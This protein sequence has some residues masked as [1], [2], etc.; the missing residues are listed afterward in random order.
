[1]GPASLWAD[2][3]PPPRWAALDRDER[4]D[5]LV[6]GAGLAGLA[7]AGELGR[8]GADVLV[9]DAEPPGAGASSRNA[10][11][12][13]VTHVWQYPELRRRLGREP[14]LEIL[15]LARRTHER[16]AAIGG[17]DHARTGS[18]VLAS[19]GDERDA[20]RTAAA[21]LADDGV[22]ALWVDPPRG[23]DGLAPAML[24]REDGVV[25]PGKL[26]AALARGVRR[27]AAAKIDAIDAGARVATCGPHTISF[28][29]AIVATNAWTRTL[30]PELWGVIEPHRAQVLV[31]APLPPFLDRPCYATYGYD[32][33]R[34]R[35]DGRLLVGGRRHLHRDDERTDDAS[36]SAS[37]Q[38]D[39]DRFV[40]AHLPA[41]AGAP[42]ERRWAGIM[43]FT[44]DH[45]PV[46]G[47]LARA[48]GVI[49]VIGGF[50]GHGVGLAI[51]CAERL[52]RLLDGERGAVPGALDPARF[53]A[54]L[55]RDRDEP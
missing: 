27:G 25:H 7:V 29:R 54:M 4:C 44:P 8:R 5:T 3:A 34:Q 9:V 35:S 55:A 38:G 39:L 16:I 37:V 52:A 42:V 13:L 48:G 2:E 53:A 32:Y 41:A 1:M 36:P 14:A 26:V 40:A 30:L 12:V 50:S 46:V 21:I 45:L 23:V 17:I 10:G 49:A 51:A 24:L 43:G 19:E 18:L 20:L 6:V 28:R 22:P 11:F 15:A 47:W 33:F 31:T